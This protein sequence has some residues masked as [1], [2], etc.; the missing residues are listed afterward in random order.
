MLRVLGLGRGSESFHFFGW[1]GPFGPKTDGVVVIPAQ[2]HFLPEVL[3]T[4][5][6]KLNLPAYITMV[7]TVSAPKTPW[8]E[9]L[10]IV[11]PCNPY[12]YS[13]VLCN[14]PVGL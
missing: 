9:C 7:S 8:S 10:L 3:L 1:K 14:V 13:H 11:V 4:G 5:Q 6:G 2:E 12:L